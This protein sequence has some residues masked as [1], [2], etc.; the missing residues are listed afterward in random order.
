MN[1]Q[2][3]IQWTS[4]TWARPD[5][6]TFS[7]Q[8]NC[9]LG[10]VGEFGELGRAQGADRRLSEAGDA[11][12]YCCRLALGLG[13][14]ISDIKREGTSGDDVVLRM[15][16]LAEYYKKALRSDYAVD[17]VRVGELIRPIVNSIVGIGFWDAWDE[18]TV[19][20]AGRFYYD[21]D[22]PEAVADWALDRLIRANVEKLEGR[23]ARGTICGS[24]EGR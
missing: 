14:E 22:T 16:A 11:L 4:K 3:Y 12:Y 1:L 18:L 13:F 5:E 10:I 15:G 6:F 21:N 19:D 7:D 8:I 20:E 9:V 2:Q 24:G 23:L 17:P